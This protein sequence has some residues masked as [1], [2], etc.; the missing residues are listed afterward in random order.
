MNLF[1]NQKLDT[2]RKLQCYSA[3]QGADTWLKTDPALQ[4]WKNLFKI[5]LLFVDDEPLPLPS[6]ILVK[7]EDLEEADNDIDNDIYQQTLDFDNLINC[8]D[9]YYYLDQNEVCFFCSE[10][11]RSKAVF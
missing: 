7:Q 5:F 10:L 9:P 3:I 4:P 1:E 11:L 6:D 2:I 8:E